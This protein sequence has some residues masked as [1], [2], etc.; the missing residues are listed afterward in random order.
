MIPFNKIYLTGKEKLYIEKALNT[1]TAGDGNYTNKCSKWLE[2][3]TGAHKVLLTTSCT[4][5]LEMAAIL[6]NIKPGDEVIMPSYTFVSTAN[7]FVLRGAIPVFIDVYENDLNINVEN[8]EKAITKKTRAIV[9]VHYAGNSCKMEK[10]KEIA[11]KYSLFIIEDAAQCIM[12]FHNGK[13]LGST[14]DLSAFSF[15]QTKNISCG[16]G[17][18]LVI[19]NP[20]LFDRAEIIREKGTNRSQYLKKQSNLYTWLDIGSSYLPSDINAAYLW[21]QLEGS[22]FIT[23][24]RLKVWKN[25]KESFSY[26]EKE[27]LIKVQTVSS[28][29]G[30]N[31]HLFYILLKDEILRNKFIKDMYKKNIICTS[32]YIPLH[33]SPFGKKV[34]KT[35]D[36]LKVTDSISKRIV[37]LPMWVDLDK[38]QNK[39]I[40][41]SIKIIQ[42]LV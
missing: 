25:Y 22:K 4:A 14:G 16:E 26:I 36:D 41:S 10:I 39:I 42:K 27:G 11:N 3:L 17:G 37:R 30:Y 21:A 34:G 7:A 6:I 13:H 32:H 24:K 5:A 31:A 29:Q 23:S 33:S 19:N 20:N 9:P 38:F 18:A 8:I 12:S 28:N 35:Q 1:Q 40:D 15:H 2:T